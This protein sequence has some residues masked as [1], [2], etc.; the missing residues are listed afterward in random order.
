LKLWSPRN[1]K[2]ITTLR[3]HTDDVSSATFSPDGTRLASVSF[4]RTLRLWDPV[5]CETV[6]SF[7][8]HREWP[9]AVAFSPDGSLLVSG[10][11]SLR[12]WRAVELPRTTTVAK[13]EAPTQEQGQ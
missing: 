7:K 13:V 12:F 9:F 3:G 4:D 2:L 5:T 10:G 8:A 1:G 6:L 11:R